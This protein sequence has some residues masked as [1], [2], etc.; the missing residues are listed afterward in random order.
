MADAPLW[1]MSS[2]LARLVMSTLMNGTS[3][4][5]TTNTR[6]TP[7]T[8][9]SSGVGFSIHGGRSERDHAWAAATGSASAG[10]VI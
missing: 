1:R 2:S 3:T 8:N 6:T 5:S 10:T 4:M 7:R 9:V